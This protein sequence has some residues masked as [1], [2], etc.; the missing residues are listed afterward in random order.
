MEL[1]IVT[2]DRTP[3][4]LGSCRYYLP[5]E[6][7]RDYGESGHAI[8]VEPVTPDTLGA[9]GPE[10]YGTVRVITDAGVRVVCTLD[11]GVLVLPS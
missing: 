3:V 9:S 10:A 6:A 5:A 4:E 8:I 7:R 1:S 11:I 2:L